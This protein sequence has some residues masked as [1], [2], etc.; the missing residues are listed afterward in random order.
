MEKHN[1]KWSKF[2]K[3]YLRT[4]A[5]ILVSAS[6]TQEE[7]NH[8]ISLADL[9]TNTPIEYLFEGK[10]VSNNNEE[11]FNDCNEVENITK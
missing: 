11:L 9:I 3:I 1:E 5:D 10:L 8:L 4:A 6:V 7:Y 2:E